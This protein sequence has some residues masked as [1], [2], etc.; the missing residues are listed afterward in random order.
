MD[1]V[2][3]HGTSWGDSKNEVGERKKSRS[4]TTLNTLSDWERALLSQATFEARLMRTIIGDPAQELQC[5]F[6]NTL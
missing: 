4:T 3:D 1:R 5:D 6:E 2:R